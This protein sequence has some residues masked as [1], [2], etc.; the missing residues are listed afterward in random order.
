MGCGSAAWM[1]L[2]LV[3]EIGYRVS[4]C[5]SNVSSAAPAQ[6]V[7]GA[8]SVMCVSSPIS[9][10]PTSHPTPAADGPCR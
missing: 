9:A 8:F 1:M 3:L 5:V 7:V 6:Y 4:S 10:E 2:V